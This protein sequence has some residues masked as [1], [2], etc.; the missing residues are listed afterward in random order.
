LTL[1][2]SVTR[3]DTEVW[4]PRGARKRQ[5][6]ELGKGAGPNWTKSE[7]GQW[8]D[9]AE[10]GW[11]EGKMFLAGDFGWPTMP[12]PNV[13]AVAATKYPVSDS[14]SA[15]FV[16]KAVGGIMA[17]LLAEL[18]DVEAQQAVSTLANPTEFVFTCSKLLDDGARRTS[19]GGPF[20]DESEP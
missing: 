10:L 8:R 12:M 2:D 20:V 1:Y 9:Y 7:I 3:C 6:R 13:R 17:V 16:A 19:G 15:G 4:R 18:D 14:L 11:G 5:I